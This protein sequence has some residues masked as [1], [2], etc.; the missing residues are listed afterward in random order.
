MT[1]NRRHTIISLAIWLA[2]L[3]LVIIALQFPTA[4]QLVDK[5]AQ[6]GYFG[7]FLAGFLY[8]IAFTSST[9][10]V[11]LAKAPDYLNPLVIALIGGLAAAVYDFIVFIFF[12]TQSAHG[13]L[14]SLHNKIFSQRKLPNWAL[15]II[16][17][18]ILG[19][20]LPDELASGFLGFL[21]FSTKKF[22]AISFIANVVGILVIVLIG[23]R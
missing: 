2:G 17:L 20:P 3:L 6:A 14:E 23:Q 15:F 22:I 10:T 13:F 19:S 9:A 21:K 12:K 18:A 11:I 16:G 1:N 5:I 8:A 7:A 4:Q